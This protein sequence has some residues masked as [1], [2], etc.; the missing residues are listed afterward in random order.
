ASAIAAVT[1]I[2]LSSVAVILRNPDWRSDEVVYLR[3]A[4]ANPESVYAWLGLGTASLN[5]GNYSQA[6]RAFEM[7]ERYSGDRRFI[8]YSDVLYLVPLGRGTLAARRNM[9]EEAE[10]Y[11][12]KAIEHNPSGS[13]AYTILAGVYLNLEKNP[14][15]AIPLLEK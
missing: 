10:T 4:E 14:G 15:A 6:E 13:D 9:P 8:R 5:Q 3:S 2:L 12:R 7:A 11:L 1:L